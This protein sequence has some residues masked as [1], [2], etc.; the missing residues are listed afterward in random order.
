MIGFGKKDTSTHNGVEKG[1]WQK[2][3]RVSAG[4]CKMKK[5]NMILKSIS[6][7]ILNQNNCR[8][9]CCAHSMLDL[10]S[11]GNSKTKMFYERSQN[12]YS[13]KGFALF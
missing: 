5:T 1:L 11:F 3:I 2:P 12:S 13:E 8:L 6:R 7:K 9:N 4:A 10:R